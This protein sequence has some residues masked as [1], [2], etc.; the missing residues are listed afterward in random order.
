MIDLVALAVA[1]G[2]SATE[3][4]RKEGWALLQSWREIYCAPVHA[5][6]GRWTPGGGPSWHTFSQGS[7]PSL[8]GKPAWREYEAQESAELLVLPE[9]DHVTAIRCASPSPLDF[10]GLFIDVYVAPP[11]FAWTM[12]FTHEHPDYGPYFARNQYPR[13]LQGAT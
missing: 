3:I 13:I 1:A 10:S 6:T 8:R 11:S 5:A 4:P 12:V 2:A 7:Y 9:E